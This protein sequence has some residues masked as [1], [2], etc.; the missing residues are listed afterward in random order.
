MKPVKKGFLEEV[1]AELNL[2]RL[3]GFNKAMRRE[4]IFPAEVTS[5]TENREAVWFV[6]T[7]QNP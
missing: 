5:G 7:I 6:Q 4:I 2:K 3:V 1:I